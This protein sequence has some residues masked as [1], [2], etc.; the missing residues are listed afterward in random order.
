MLSVSKE[1]RKGKKSENYRLTPDLESTH[2]THEDTL[3]ERKGEDTPLR[4]LD[5]TD[6]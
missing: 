4:T 1:K 2:S 5:S 6:L 3:G